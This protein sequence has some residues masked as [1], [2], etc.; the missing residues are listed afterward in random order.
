MGGPNA[1]GYTTAN[2]TAATKVAS[3]HEDFAD[4]NGGDHNAQPLKQRARQVSCQETISSRAHIPLNRAMYAYN[5][6]ADDP[7]EV[8]FAKGDILEVLDNTG[9][10]FQVRTTA[11][12]TGVSPTQFSHILISDR[13]IKLSYDALSWSREAESQLQCMLYNIQQIS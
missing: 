3:P 2:D 9:K 1:S 7:N 5:A 11:G 4:L 10:W 12:H 8:S 13:T 6:S